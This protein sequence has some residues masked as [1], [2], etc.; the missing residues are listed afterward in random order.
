[1]EI[2][3]SGDVKA[4]EYDPGEISYP[5]R[6]EIRPY[7]SLNQIDLFDGTWIL[8]QPMYTCKT[9]GKSE[10]QIRSRYQMKYEQPNS[11]PF[12]P[13]ELS[14]LKGFTVVQ[15]TRTDLHFYYVISYCIVTRS[16]EFR[17]KKSSSR[18]RRVIL[19]YCGRLIEK[20]KKK[21][22]NKKKKDTFVC[23]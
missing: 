12:S 22:S 1:M 13:R 19:S 5:T 20:K 2:K 23:A 16:A 11:D 10:D 9:V 18:Q 21:R 17:D 3:V 15:Q 14:L 6:L 8:V 4:K 7:Q